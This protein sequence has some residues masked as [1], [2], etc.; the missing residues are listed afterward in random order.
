MDVRRDMDFELNKEEKR[1]IAALKRLEKIW[2]QSLWLF[3][4]S[5]SLHVMKAGKQNEP[6]HSGGEAGGVDSDYVITT[7]Y[8][9]QNDGGDW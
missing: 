5:G 2:P 7:I 1:A 4:G 9:I 3:S 8:G 6:V